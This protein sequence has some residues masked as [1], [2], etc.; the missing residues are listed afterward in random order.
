MKKKIFYRKKVEQKA[1]A[2]L[3]IKNLFVLCIWNRWSE[4]F[5][6]RALH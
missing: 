5:T 2:P 3:Y 1:I 4:I 6:R